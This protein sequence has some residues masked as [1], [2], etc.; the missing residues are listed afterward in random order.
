M[1]VFDKFTGDE[2]GEVQSIRIEEIVDD[3]EDAQEKK[4]SLEEKIEIL[5][6]GSKII[7]DNQDFLSDV[8]SMETGKTLNSATLEIIKAEKF[9][10]NPFIFASRTPEM[11]NNSQAGENSKTLFN[12]PEGAPVLAYSSNIIENTLNGKTSVA[13]HN[14]VCPLT[15]MKISEVLS[16]AINDWKYVVIDALPDDINK[17]IKKACESEFIGEVRFKGLYEQ[18]MGISKISGLKNIT[19]SVMGNSRAIIWDKKYME[20]ALDWVL[21]KSMKP[22]SNH[23]ERVQT[24]IVKAEFFT[25]FKNRMIE[26]SKKLILGNPRE[27]GTELQYYHSEVEEKR[28]VDTVKTLAKEGYI[29]EADENKRFPIILQNEYPDMGAKIQDFDGP[30][31]ILVSSK[32][33]IDALEFSFR[34]K[35]WD[36]THLFANGVEEF[37]FSK[38][39]LGNSKLIINPSYEEKG[40]SGKE[41]RKGF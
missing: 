1:K 13:L 31:A 36:V 25:Y 21:D 32:S 33:L 12:I 24:V 30:I 41:I 7:S 10:L 29:L 39:N 15:T 27:K 35:P 11:N 4:I 37:E 28:A 19:F 40:I 2:I 14:P 9:F 34:N 20:H 22:L 3:Y 38:N 8:L 6:K 17:A 18:C 26:L 5:R 23:R 16:E